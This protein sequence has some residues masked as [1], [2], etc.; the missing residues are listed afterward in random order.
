MVEARKNGLLAA[1]LK[2]AAEGE[3]EKRAAA[4]RAKALRST[5]LS[6]STCYELVE[7]QDRIGGAWVVAEREEGGYAR[8]VGFKC[9][10]G[11]AVIGRPAMCRA[12]VGAFRGI[13]EDAG[14][15]A[16][17]VLTRS[18]AKG[19]GRCEVMVCCREKARRCA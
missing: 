18:I 12:T 15:D 17:V 9:P 8:L 7:Y 10:F 2:A 4:E 19:D 11:D 13:L 16:S 5:G 14:R 3:C 1:M 6:K